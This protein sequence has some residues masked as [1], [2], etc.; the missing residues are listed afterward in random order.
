[1]G[2]IIRLA[3]PTPRIPSCQ[4]TLSTNIN[5]FAKVCAMLLFAP[6]MAKL[7]VIYPQVKVFASPKIST[8]KKLEVVP[9]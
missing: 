8:R 3:W 4:A 2:H 9:F 1:M 6:S 7:P 5:E